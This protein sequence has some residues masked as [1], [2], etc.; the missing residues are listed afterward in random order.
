KHLYIPKIEEGVVIDHIPAGLGPKVAEIICGAPGLQDAMVSLGLNYGSTRIGRK[1]MVKLHERHLPEGVLD[2]ISLV[3]PGVTIKRVEG[4]AVVERVVLDPPRLI[5]GL[6]RCRNP[7]C[8]TNTEAGVITRFVA[9]DPEA[10]TYRC[11]F[12]ERAFKLRDLPVTLSGAT[13]GRCLE[14][15]GKA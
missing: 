10:R 3:A 9:V 5:V 11:A 14:R 7:N 1:D 15:G 8:V 4:F 6:A 2:Q 13:W 12:C